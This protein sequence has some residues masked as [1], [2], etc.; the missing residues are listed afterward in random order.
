MTAPFLGILV[1]SK[2][3][4]STD[5]HEEDE[6]EDEA[7]GNGAHVGEWHGAYPDGLDLAERRKLLGERLPLGLERQVPHEDRPQ[8]LALVVERLLL[9]LPCP[10]R[11]SHLFGHLPLL[12]DDRKRRRGCAAEPPPLVAGLDL[13]PLPLAPGLIPARLRGRLSD[14]GFGVL[15]SGRRGD[16]RR[17]SGLVVGGLAAE[18]VV[19]GEEGADGRGVVGRGLLVLLRHSRRRCEATARRFAA[20]AVGLGFGGGGGNS[21][22]AGF[23][24]VGTRPRIG[25]RLGRSRPLDSDRTARIC[26]YP[27]HEPRWHGRTRGGQ[28]EGVGGGGFLGFLEFDDR[29]RRHAGSHRRRREDGGEPRGRAEPEPAPPLLLH[30][31][32]SRPRPWL[33]AV[34]SGGHHRARRR[35][36][37]KAGNQEGGES[38]EGIH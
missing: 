25:D 13:V 2:A 28:E 21:F 12:P 30:T 5:K 3:Q 18:G 17:W 16:G 6:D 22:V 38:R 26:L 32:P 9:L 19:C 27:W 29:R 31:Q 36:R 35:V 4:I 7:Q 34:G 23:R 10:R 8:Q 20:A 33:R 11:R 15:A 37:A 1:C 24:L 14:L